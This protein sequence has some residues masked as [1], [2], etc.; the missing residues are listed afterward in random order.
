M[1]KN[2]ISREQLAENIRALVMAFS[3]TKLQKESGLGLRTLD[4]YLSGDS[5]PKVT[6]ALAMARILGTTVEYMTLREGPK[7]FSSHDL[8]D[9]QQLTEQVKESAIDYSSA[10]KRDALEDLHN[11]HKVLLGMKRSSGLKRENLVLKSVDSNSM[12]GF[13][14]G[15]MVLVDSSDQELSDGNLF[16]LTFMG[17]GLIREASLVPGKGWLLRTNNDKHEDLLFDI[18]LAGL[19]VEGRL[20]SI[21]KFF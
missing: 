7:S 13:K 10:S 18:D 15:D 20:I 14:K 17:A 3:R 21:T 1:F 4:N 16:Y 8:A 6:A 5:E 19:K 11:S 12:D 2:L 9:Y